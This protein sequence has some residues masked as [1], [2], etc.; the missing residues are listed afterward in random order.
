[1]HPHWLAPCRLQP[2]RHA[3]LLVRP[4]LAAAAVPRALAHS[5]ALGRPRLSL[6]PRLLPPS[7]CRRGLVVG[8]YVGDCGLMWHVK[9]EMEWLAQWPQSGMVL[10]WR[11]STA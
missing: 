3:P 10:P 1:M 2:Q 4:L 8:Y 5:T 9:L 6:W 7:P 11:Y